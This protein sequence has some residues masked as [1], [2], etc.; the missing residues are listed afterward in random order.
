MHSWEI[1]VAVIGYFYLQRFI[2][3]RADMPLDL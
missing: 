3:Q 2:K 1:D